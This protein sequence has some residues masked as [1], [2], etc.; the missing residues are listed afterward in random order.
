MTGVQFLVG[1]GT[2]LFA[3][4]SR[5]VQVPTQ[6]PIQWVLMAVSLGVKWLVHEADHSLPYSVEV[7]NEWSYILTPPFI[8]MS[9]SSIKQRNNFTF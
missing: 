8:F 3:T 1:T 4:R 6:L 5:L 7:K 9:Q 2:L